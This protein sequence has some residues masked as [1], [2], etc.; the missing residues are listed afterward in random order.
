[1]KN[2]KTIY[3][4]LII[5]AA[6]FLGFFDLPADTQKQL[7]PSTPSTITENK[8]HLGLDLQGG[9]QLDYKIDLR[10]VAENDRKSIIEGVLNIIND[11][12]NKLGVSEPSIYTSNYGDETHII[13]ELAGIKDLDEAKNTVGKTIQLEFK[14]LK[15]SQNQD[16]TEKVEKQTK[17]EATK[18][19]A[20][21]KE[22][23][24]IDVI[25]NEEALANPETVKFTQETEFK[26]KDEIPTDIA[27][28]I[29]K[30]NKDELSEVIE[31]D[32]SY[33]LN[34][35]TQKL[36]QTAKSYY[37]AQIT[38]KTEKEKT[39]TTPKSVETSHILIAYKGA[40]R[41]DEKITRT[42]EEA[43][44]R[45]EEVLKK[46]KDGGKFEDLVK[47]YS[48]DSSAKQNNGKLDK[49]VTEKNS[50]YVKEYT[51]A[52]L[53]LEKDGQL[54]DLV[55]SPFGF[56]I[57]KADKVI[58]EKTETKKEPQIKYSLITYKAEVSK[59]E[60]TKLNGKHFKHADVS[61]SN[62]MNP[63]VTIEFDDEGATLFG[64]LTKA[65]VGKPIAIFVG[66]KLISSP[67]VNEAILGG[68][69]QI[70]G[71]FSV[72]EANKLARD[73]NTGAIPAPIIL[74]GQYK[75]GATLGQNALS[76]SLNAGLI[77]F[78]I[79]ALF[80]ILYYRLQ[81]VLATIALT[82]YS[83][84]LL[85]M[86]K[87]AIPMIWG[88]LIA[89]GIFVYLVLKITQSKDSFAEKTI[90]TILVT[91]GLFF[92]SFILSTPIVL[93][94]A[95]IAGVLLS[96][97]MAVD[98]N[99][100]I[101]ERIKEE[102]R[103]GRSLETATEVGFQRAWSSIRDSNFSSLITSAILFYFGNSIIQGFAFNLAAG[104]LISM[105]TA[106]TITKT[107]LDV[108]IKTKLKN[109]KWLFGYT[110]KKPKL[111]Q[112][113]KYRKYLYSLSAILILISIIGTLT[114]GVRLG[115]D[116][117]GGTLIEIN[118]T[119]K[120]LTIEQVKQAVLDSQESIKSTNTAKAT[121]E[122]PKTADTTKNTQTDTN[123]QDTILEAATTNVDLSKNKI[124]E[125]DTGFIIKIP[126]ISN[127]AHDKL[128]QNL[129]T[130]LGDFEE[131]RFQAVGPTV[132]ENLQ[133]KAIM[134]IIIA[135]I[136][137]VMY[138]ALAFRK[139]PRYIGKWKFGVTAIAAL[140][141]DLTIMFGVYIFLGAFLN[142]EIDA[143]FITAML[144]V[145][146]FSVHDTI[147]VFDRL[148]ERLKYQKKD[149]TF[150]E[151]ANKAINETMARSL[152]TSISTFIVL[153]V[154]FLIGAPSV[155]FF[156]LSLIIGIL[157]GTYSS[158]FI[159]TPFLL[160]WQIYSKKQNKK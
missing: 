32:P 4:G 113:I 104:I 66:G 147:V 31:G 82:I 30:L 25:G 77:G 86:I 7:I 151:V 63:Y 110:T 5:V 142:V 159:A 53:T 139:I 1:M 22:G 135:S 124:I 24:N 138:I 64:E 140:I 6:L 12:V 42:E 8:V 76:S 13:V 130:K 52:S 10:K 39:T 59:W 95:G 19:L 136:I 37:L 11:R 15:A 14:T 156:I 16:E 73:L 9:A 71:N 91:F 129:K 149:E 132:G 48:D 75:I 72:E 109:Y 146:G 83:I 120:N 34:P 105:F 58:P 62:T 160:D 2:R 125:S 99:I 97:G 80:M 128:L 106:I 93:T 123:S 152:N 88:I 141:H 55:K 17:E 112:I 21:L 69:A 90:S 131:T 57:I 137:I 87:S 103:D 107:M 144:T 46:L 116:F 70:T 157:S 96:I 40:Q 154:M 111:L 45:A 121:I 41:A 26:F 54:S 119:N 150:E 68:H 18:A 148:R 92:I 85:F 51:D 89:I 3:L 78:L 101:F 158:I 102:L 134:A 47:E 56:H 127:T 122:D 81:G 50:S 20:Q 133:F 153:I 23:K 155:K 84:L 79:L 115:L 33:R 38:D 108:V 28:A 94:L 65:N 43:K 145:L 126:T 29:F 27:D 117:T 35:E 118:P 36:E 61:F 44:T 74:A 49:P 100:L 60:D 98:A 67:R 143:L 114:F